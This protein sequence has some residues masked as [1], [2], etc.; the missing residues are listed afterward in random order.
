MIIYRLVCFIFVCLCVCL[1]VCVCVCVCVCFVIQ[2]TF[3]NKKPKNTNHALSHLIPKKPESQ[4]QPS[5]PP[6]RQSPE[7]TRKVHVRNNR[8]AE[9]KGMVQTLIGTIAT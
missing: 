4:M 6:G 3:K 9:K 2:I 7:H 1:C 5:A 8:I